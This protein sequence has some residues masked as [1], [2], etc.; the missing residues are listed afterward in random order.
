MPLR[1]RTLEYNYQNYIYCVRVLLVASANGKIDVA[2]GLSH[3]RQTRT[4]MNLQSVRAVNEFAVSAEKKFWSD[5]QIH[6]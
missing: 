3:E 6:D 5:I 4:S 1:T 2:G